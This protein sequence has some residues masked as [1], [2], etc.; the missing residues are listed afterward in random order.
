[1]TL[2]R[3]MI[4]GGLIGGLLLLASYFSGV[5]VNL[6]GANPSIITSKAKT[7]TATTT[8][9]YMTPGTATTTLVYDSQQSDGTN[10]TNNGNTWATNGAILF[11]QFTASNTSSVLNTHFEYSDD[12]SCGTTPTSCDWYRDTL[13]GD[14]FATST[15]T[16]QMA[17]TPSYTWNYAST[18][19]GGSAGINIYRGLKAI[20][21]P[22][23][24]RFVR[25]VFTVPI[26]SQNGAVYAE[27]IPKK[28]VAI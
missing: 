12:P 28:E 16:I 24:S 27:I 9:R 7:A 8:L 6:A 19:Q 10:Q 26:G 18:T 25:V 23:P 15:A 21:I 20:N 4:F 2:K 13:W 11:V 22:T 5:Y 3:Q 1:M 14:S 17:I